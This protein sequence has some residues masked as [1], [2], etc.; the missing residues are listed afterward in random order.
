MLEEIRHWLNRVVDLY[1]KRTDIPRSLKV[2]GPELNDFI[3]KVQSLELAGKSPEEI[4]R[5][6]Y[7]ETK[8]K[9]L[10][11]DAQAKSLYEQVRRA[12]KKA[13]RL[14]NNK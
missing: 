11:A 3:L 4:T 10:N 5:E 6:L 2:R 12:S 14:I 13:K 9:S 7:P 8:G 1:F